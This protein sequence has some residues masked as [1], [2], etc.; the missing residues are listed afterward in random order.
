MTSVTKNDMLAGFRKLV[1]R[2]GMILEVH[3]SLSAFG[4]V[5]GGAETVISALKECVGEKGSI[6]MPAFLLSDRYP[7]TEEDKALGL[8]LK[9]RYLT[10]DD[11]RSGMGI[12]ADT[13]RRANDVVVGSGTF[14]CAAWGK[15]S[16]RLA[17]GWDKVVASGAYA[18][19]LGVDIYRFTGMHTAEK[20]LPDNIKECFK[21]SDEVLK[22]YPP[23]QWMTEA[24]ECPSKPWY[25]IQDEA[26]RRKLIRTETIGE[27]PCMF[28]RAKDVT[29][30]YKKALK[31]NPYELYGVCP[32]QGKI[33]LKEK[34]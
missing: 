22:K 26:F 34:R 4:Y 32:R 21:P 20:H 24:W 8:T 29:D 2:E 1:V 16:E 5:E 31:K 13:F 10:D 11:E 14:R 18:L 17:R 6:V 30:L 33:L 19:L 27:C 12:I 28:F 7:L 3:S 9:L 15:A 23:N 25:K